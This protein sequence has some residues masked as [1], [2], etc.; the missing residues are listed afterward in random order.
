MK[1][2]GFPNTRSARSAWS[3]EEA[4]A[5]FEYIHIDLLKGAGRSPEFLQINPAGKLPALV[6]GDLVITESAAISWYIAEKF[7]DAKL[8]PS[9]S[10]DRARCMQWC[11]FALT[12]LEQPVW[13][14]SKHTFA[15][16]EK[17]R[18]PSIMAT[19][20]WEFVRAA[21]VLATGLGEKEYILGNAFSIADIL[22]ANTLNW[23]RSRNVE[24]VS[25]ALNAYA[26]RLLA[27]P[28]LQRA[29]ARERAAAG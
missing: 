15:L 22:L 25:T 13:T 3:L 20:N 9:D 10:A 1:L 14:I 18:V 4:G 11:F 8:L 24:I 19:A 17:Q 27:R 23:A 21:K 12:E 26:D 29:L 7:P 5:D 2:Y 6:D 16:P 28:A